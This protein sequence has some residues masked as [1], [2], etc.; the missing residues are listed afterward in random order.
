VV[1]IN[2]EVDL[3]LEVGIKIIIQPQAYE[4]IRSGQN[5]RNLHYDLDFSIVENPHQHFHSWTKNWKRSVVR[6][7]M[8]GLCSCWTRRWS[9]EMMLNDDVEG[10]GGPDRDRCGGVWRTRQG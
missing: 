6:K 5:E 2:V 3:D 9:R 7:E 10:C 4:R 1:D 8:R